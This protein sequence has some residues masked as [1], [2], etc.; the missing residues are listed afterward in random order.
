MTALFATKENFPEN[1][2]DLI[3]LLITNQ[4]IKA[5]DITPK[6]FKDLKNSN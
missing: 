1:N 4:T 6:A 2:E 3:L 5:F